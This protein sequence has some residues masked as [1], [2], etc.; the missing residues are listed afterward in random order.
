MRFTLL[1]TILAGVAGMT[2]CAPAV[3]IHPLFTTQDLVSDL[4]LEGAWT[5]QDGEIWRIQKSGD[6]Y[7][8]A[9]V[10]AG[11][12]KEVS[13]FNVH[14]LRLK[15]SEFVDVASKSDP[16]VGVAGHLFGKIRMEGDELYVS[17]ID[18]TWLKHMAEA[19]Q[20]PQ[21]IVGEGRQLVLTA[22]TSELQKFILLHAADPDAW[23]ND[24]EGLHRVH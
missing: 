6:G 15:D 23:D 14:L 1:L 2:G 20:A 17:L 13:E 5:T 10:P 9:A 12:S 24:E 18:E 7:D 4:P 19:G 3:A 11:N 21:S 22:S 8:V 16:E